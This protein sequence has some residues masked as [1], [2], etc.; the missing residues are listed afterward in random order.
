[1]CLVW[2]AQSVVL[3]LVAVPEAGPLVEVL[4]AAARPAVVRRRLG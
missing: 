2:E 4:L 1:M 3:Q